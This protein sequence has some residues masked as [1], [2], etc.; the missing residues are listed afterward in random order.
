MPM[1]M[2]LLHFSPISL[3]EGRVYIMEQLIRDK[4]PYFQYIL[5]DQT[6]SVKLPL[7]VS[8]GKIT[9]LKGRWGIND[10]ETEIPS[11][12]SFSNN[13]IWGNFQPVIK[14]PK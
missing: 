12:T 10:F 7:T 8:S 13:V 4:H 3:V 11:S 9:I 6:P 5:H 14:L 1:E 2:Y